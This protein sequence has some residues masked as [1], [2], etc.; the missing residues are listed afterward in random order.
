M[1]KPPDNNTKLSETLMLSE[2]TSPK[3]GNFGFWLYDK[4][5]GMN[6]AMHAESERNAFVHALHYYQ[7]RL[8]QVEKEH[9]YLQAQVQ[10]FVGQFVGDDQ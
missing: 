2:Y 6:L 1:S 7:T 3:N 8:T 9:A 10:A 5:R 4:T